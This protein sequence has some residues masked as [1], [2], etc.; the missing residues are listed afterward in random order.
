[1]NRSRT[2]S[3]PS[4]RRTPS[5]LLFQQLPVLFFFFLLTATASFAQQ[6]SRADQLNDEQII[7]FY[8]RAQSSGLTE[9]QIEQAAMSQGYTVSDIA[10]M[11]QRMAKI[12]QQSNRPGQM[13]TDTLLNR[14][15]QG[16]LSQRPYTLGDSLSM[17]RRDTTRRPYIFG[18]ALFKGTTLTF[19]PDLR[20]ATPRN[21]VVGPDDELAVEI[22]GNS[23]ESFRLRVSPEGSV[24]VLNLAPIFVSGLTIE[25]AE[26]RIVGRLR[27]AYQG[28]N[29]PG[30]GTYASVTL[31]S[32]RSIRV[33]LVGEV[34]M[35]GTYT[36]SSLATAFNALYLA[37]GP[38]PETGSFRDIQVIRNNRV[39]RTI[40]LY[41]YLLRADKKDDIRLL[42][43]DVI[44]VNDYGVR[45]EVLGQVKRP[46]IYEV[47]TGETLKNVLSFAG[48]F[49]DRAYTF[50]LTLRRNTPRELR[51]ST[52][53]QEQIATFVPQAGD[54]YTVGEILGR[55]ENRVQVT[56]AVMRP[57]DYAL[58]D[59]I[60]SVRSLISRAEGLRKDAFLNRA[61]LY[62]ERENT[63]LEAIP[64]DVGRLMRNETD[65]I[66]LERQ[67][68]LHIYSVRDLREPYFISIE[69]AVNRPDTLPFISNLTVT[70]LIALAGGFQ[71]G[72]TPTRIEVA[73]RIREDTTKMTGRETVQIYQFAID[74]NL[75]LQPAEA[76]FVL[77]PF[78]VVYVR[79]SPR[80]ELQQNVAVFG[81]VQH[82]GNYAIESRSERISDMLRRVGG[83]KPEAFLPGA[84]FSRRGIVIATDLG[85][86]L[87]NPGVPGNL[88]LEVGDSLIIPKR[89]E[90]VTIEGAVLNPSTVGFAEGFNFKDYVTQAGGYTDNARHKKSYVV[91]ANGLKDRTKRFLFF[92]KYP[93]V[94][95]GSRVIVPFG[96]LTED[97]RLTPGERVSLIT[98]IGTMT[99]TLATAVLNLARL[100]N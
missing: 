98:V 4:T 28:L 23:S 38:N 33:T 11:R 80:Y 95:P 50:S 86:I 74:R 20:I 2:P 60:T 49:T 15:Q 53:T 30:S 41:D 3:Y 63:D 81:E 13:S 90:V 88:L 72:A 93:K 66:P 9:M 52:I 76:R 65:D 39:I 16:N 47:K 19:E 58:G 92:R 42:D 17:L 70:D 82:P 37:G 64:F 96:P 85:A 27:L 54:R 7:Q 43:Q 62:R 94:E 6:P 78:D 100:F 71:E 29:R 68:S 12:R 10:K 34:M 21:Y 57:G 26:Q 1:M 24:R 73:R 77:K 99:V 44:R 14:A 35:P 59:G 31:G 75:Q 48:G 25:Q 84:R 61:V 91:Y 69:G 32:I 18:A 56:G 83:L 5:F 40:D 97:R 87:E 55:Y 89:P 22:Y 79:T 67:D 51:I 45:V 8:Q 36:I 46:A